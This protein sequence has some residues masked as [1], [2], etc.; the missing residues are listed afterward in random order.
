MKDSPQLEK[1]KKVR[2]GVEH[3]IS[4]RFKAE[5]EIPNV[6]VVVGENLEKHPKNVH[7]N[8]KR[9]LDLGKEYATYFLEFIN[10]K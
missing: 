3:G 4:V 6:R 8:T 2:P 9:Q 1:V 7:Y 5:K 10:K